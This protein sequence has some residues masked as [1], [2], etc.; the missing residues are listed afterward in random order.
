M[1]S[2]AGING[3]FATA[4]NIINV[5]TPGTPGPPPAPP[6]LVLKINHINGNIASAPNLLTDN[7]IFGYDP[8]TGQVLRFNL[9]PENATTS[10]PNMAKQT[11]TLDPTWTPLQVQP[12]GSTRR[13]RSRWDTT[14]TGWFCWSA[15][16]L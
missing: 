3:E 11:G 9:T 10:Q 1:Q 12:P 8:M 4:G 6:G 13:S 15:R 2:L 16:D 5:S 7:V 14:T